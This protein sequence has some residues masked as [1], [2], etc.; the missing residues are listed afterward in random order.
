MHRAL[1]AGASAVAAGAM[2]QWEDATPREAA[3]YLQGKGWEVRL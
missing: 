3:E 2:F 1:K